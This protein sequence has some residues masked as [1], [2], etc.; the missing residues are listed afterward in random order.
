MGDFEDWEKNKEAFQCMN[1]SLRIN[2]TLN[3]KTHKLQGD[4]PI[5]MWQAFLTTP[6]ICELADFVILLLSMSVNQAGLEH[7]FLDLK[8]KKT[9][10]QN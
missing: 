4:N 5:V 7:S 10:L 8:I 1:V 3:V 2:H 6:S 9:H